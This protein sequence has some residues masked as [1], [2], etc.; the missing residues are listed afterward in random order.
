IRERVAAVRAR[1]RVENSTARRLSLLRTGSGVN[2]PSWR[3]DRLLGQSLEDVV[4]DCITGA[5]DRNPYVWLWRPID[6]SDGSRMPEPRR[7]AVHR[8]VRLM[9]AGVTAPHLDLNNDCA[10]NTRTVEVRAPRS[11]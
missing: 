8:G 1:P 3:F 4:G 6:D 2:Y 9:H 10:R 5:Q 7:K 11:V